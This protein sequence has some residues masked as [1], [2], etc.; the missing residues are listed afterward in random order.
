MVYQQHLTRLLDQYNS[1]GGVA[2]TEEN[3]KYRQLKCYVCE[4]CYFYS[5]KGKYSKYVCMWDITSCFVGHMHIDVHTFVV[6]EP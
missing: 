6:S 1:H 3:L 2:K 4:Y 5:F